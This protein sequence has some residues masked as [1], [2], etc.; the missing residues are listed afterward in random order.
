[1][2][3]GVGAGGGPGAGEVD[4]LKPL[5]DWVENAIA[6][7]YIVAEHRTNGIVDNQRR[8]CAYPQH[9]VYAGPAGGQN[10]PANWIE[11]NFSCK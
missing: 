8:V 6:P 7:D 5:V 3:D 11:R 10:D 9:A 1:M 4:P 2:N